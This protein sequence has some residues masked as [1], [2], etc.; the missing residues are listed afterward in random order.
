M[1]EFLT[2]GKL[3]VRSGTQ[4]V[5]LLPS[6]RQLSRH[7]RNEDCDGTSIDRGKVNHVAETTD[8]CLRQEDGQ[9]KQ[10]NHAQ[11]QDISCQVNASLVK[12]FPN[13]VPRKLEVD[14]RLPAWLGGG[15]HA[16]ND[17][18]AWNA[19]GASAG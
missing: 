2:D 11:Q 1:V 16:L 15:S 7:P 4:V 9:R 3:G 14:M 13:R 6:L 19:R 5:K 18:A 10:R 8:V 17:V 12:V